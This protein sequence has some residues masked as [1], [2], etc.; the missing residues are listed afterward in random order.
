VTGRPRSDLLDL[1]DRVVDEVVA[2]PGIA[3]RPRD[4]RVAVRGRE[5]D[6]RRIVSAL[7]KVGGITLP[8]PRLGRPKKGIPNSKAGS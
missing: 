4:L 5:A 7:R 1:L 3:G 6:V 8:V 2:D